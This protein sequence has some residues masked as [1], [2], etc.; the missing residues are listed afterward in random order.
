MSNDDREER[1]DEICA[2]FLDAVDAGQPFDKD[3]ALAGNPDLAESLQNFFRDHA[4]MAG[5]LD[6]EDTGAHSP[7]G[8]LDST[9][10]HS[11]HRTI[12]LNGN[13]TDERSGF[14]TGETEPGRAR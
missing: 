12:A 4:R 3:Q 2:D 7:P 14:G 1:F 5:V 6:V 9:D 11:V 10:S 8:S 13:R